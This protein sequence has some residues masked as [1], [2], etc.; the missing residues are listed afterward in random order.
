MVLPLDI[1]WT[2]QSWLLGSGMSYELLGNFQLSHLL[3]LFRDYWLCEMR[4][5]DSS[6]DSQQAGIHRCQGRLNPIIANASLHFLHH[7][8]LSCR[9]RGLALYCQS[10][11]LTHV[12]IYIPQHLTTRGAGFWCNSSSATLYRFF[13]IHTFWPQNPKCIP[14]NTMS[15][16]IYSLLK[17]AKGS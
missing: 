6:W 5:G 1:L 11:T 8:N 14:A 12:S 3:V 2:H 13:L 17:V 16:S 15:S 7:C 9:H 10:N 4:R